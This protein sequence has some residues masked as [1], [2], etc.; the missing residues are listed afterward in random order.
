LAKRLHHYQVALEWTGNLG[1]GTAGYTAFSRDHLLRV[2]GR[3]PI[4]GS[5]DPAF[6]GT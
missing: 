1:P 6:S 2:P 4:E 5:S 3:M